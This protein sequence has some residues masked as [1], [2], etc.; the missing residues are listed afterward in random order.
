MLLQSNSLLIKLYV[1]EKRRKIK[2]Q[3]ISDF[4]QIGETGISVGIHV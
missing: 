2:I 1:L 3:H 4:N